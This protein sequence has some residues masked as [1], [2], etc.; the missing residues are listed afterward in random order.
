[1]EF[2][3]GPSL[4]GK[5]ISIFTNHPLDEVTDFDREKYNLVEWTSRDEDACGS[6]HKDD[7]CYYAQLRIY[8]AGSFRY[9]FGELEGYA[10]K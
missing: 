4:F 8:K 6:K 10:C 9:Y 7:T 5:E 1:M 2:Q 3:L